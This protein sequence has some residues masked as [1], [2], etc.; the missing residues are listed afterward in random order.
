MVTVSSGCAIIEE[1]RL[2]NDSD[3]GDE[4]L[5]SW[6]GISRVGTQRP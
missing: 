3:S 5:L 1:Y 2:M 6:Q 4:A